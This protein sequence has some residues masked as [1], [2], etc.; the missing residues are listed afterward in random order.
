MKK[1]LLAI[2][3]VTL[4]GITVSKAEAGR[5]G[6]GRPIV[7]YGWARPIGP[8]VVAPRY[9]RPAYVARPFYYGPYYDG[10]APWRTGVIVRGGY[11]G[12]GGVIVRTPG[13]G[14]DIRY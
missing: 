7:S 14:L 13:F 6:Y 10:Y 12:G 5:W 2:V 8:V 9:Y 3:A 4:V 11:Y 1:I